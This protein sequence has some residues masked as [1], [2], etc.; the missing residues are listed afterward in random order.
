MQY[1]KIHGS[2]PTYF[3]R[4]DLQNLSEVAAAL[5][6]VAGWLTAPFAIHFDE[7]GI[8]WIS[9]LNMAFDLLTA[10]EAAPFREKYDNEY[11]NFAWVESLDE[12]YDGL[13]SDEATNIRNAYRDAPG[14]DK[15]FGDILEDGELIGFPAVKP[16]YLHYIVLHDLTHDE[17]NNSVEVSLKIFFRYGNFFHDAYKLDETF[18]GDIHPDGISLPKNALE[19][20]SVVTFSFVLE[21]ETYRITSIELT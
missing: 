7:D 3:E 16:D 20:C 21:G 11:E 13:F 19:E 1:T 4:P 10:S 5:V 12:F 18:S 6:Q 17:D 9:P 2:Y 15:S 14:T 8:A